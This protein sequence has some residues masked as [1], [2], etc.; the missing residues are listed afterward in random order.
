ML[1]ISLRKV[2]KKDWKFILKLRNTKKF[3]NA[4]YD[5][6]TIT[7]EEH[8]K[9][10]RRQQSNTNFVN[11]II[12]YEGNDVG[13]IRILENDVSIMISEEYN[14]KG[15]GTKTL[16][17]VELEAKKL[18]IKKLVGRVM[19]HNKSSQKIFIKNKYKPLM[20]WY[21]KQISRR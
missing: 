12:C 5:Q 13:Y 10:L 16:H 20:Y 11:W 8:Y 9:Y 1:K 6:H 14:S 18:G 17:L 15:I 2:T 7:L 3:R 4:F 21:E 19:I